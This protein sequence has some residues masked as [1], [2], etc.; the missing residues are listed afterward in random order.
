MGEGKLRQR[1]KKFSRKDVSPN[2][3]LL[4][5]VDNASH[6][7]S[8]SNST[9]THARSASQLSASENSDTTLWDD[10]YD[11]LKDEKPELISLYEDLLSRVL[12]TG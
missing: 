12:A 11:A 4:R 7:S 8:L 3:S 6:T 5:V 1:L 9:S 2:S 10:A